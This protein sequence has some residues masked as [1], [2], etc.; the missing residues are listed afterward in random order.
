M[1]AEVQHRTDN[2]ENILV[3]CRDKVKALTKSPSSTISALIVVVLSITLLSRLFHPPAAGPVPD[4]IKVAGLA[5]SFE[6]LIHYS[7]NGAQQMGGLQET[8]VAVWDLAESVR[9]TNMESAP[10][11]VEDLDNLSEN[12]KLMV[13]ELTRFFANVDGDVD[14]SVIRKRS[15]EVES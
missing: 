1:R 2:V 11:I 9:Y 14:R 10:A 13:I 15:W 6:P 3:H 12:L 4:L 7:E 5:R 8:S